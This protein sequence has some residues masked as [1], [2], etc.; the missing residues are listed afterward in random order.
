MKQRWCHN[1][2][3]TQNPEEVS[4]NWKLHPVG[5]KERLCG[6]K[7]VGG[8]RTGSGR[9]RKRWRFL[10]QTSYYCVKATL[11]LKRSDFFPFPSYELALMC[12]RFLTTLQLKQQQSVS[13]QTAQ[14]M[15]GLSVELNATAIS[16][17][18]MKMDEMFNILLEKLSI[19][20]TVIFTYSG[21]TC[22]QQTTACSSCLFLPPGFSGWGR[23]FRRPWNVFV[24]I[25]VWFSSNNRS[26]KHLQCSHFPLFNRMW[27]HPVDK[28]WTTCKTILSSSKCSDESLT[29]SHKLPD[30]LQLFLLSK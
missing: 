28:L 29:L 8:S 26:R 5:R 13:F 6:I 18:E 22:R 30:Y 15:C 17:P 3:R 23:H 21:L 10:T 20:T 2:L 16:P 19:H 24:I 12:K 14:P 7:L 27:W 4:P 9:R 1:L 11:H 25:P